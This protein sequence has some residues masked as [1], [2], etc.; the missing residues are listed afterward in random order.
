MVVAWQFTEM[1]IWNSYNKYWI[2]TIIYNELYNYS[3]IE[4]VWHVLDFK[5]FSVNWNKN[6]SFPPIWKLISFPNLAKD[7]VNQPCNLTVVLGLSRC[8]GGLQLKIKNSFKTNT[9]TERITNFCQ[10]VH[11]CG[12][13]Q[14]HEE[15]FKGVS[16]HRPTALRK[17]ASIAA[18]KNG[19]YFLSLFAW[20]FLD[21]NFL[22]SFLTPFYKLI[23]F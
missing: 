22:P 21:K 1:W 23:E 14:F 17:M 9:K 6:P 10:Y 18:L 8:Q 5:T 3:V 15:G 20:L 7:Y 13:S 12:G 4:C 19:M 11:C 2:S 16:I